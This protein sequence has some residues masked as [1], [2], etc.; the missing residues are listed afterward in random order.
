MKTLGAI[1]ANDVGAAKEIL[2]RTYEILDGIDMASLN[3]PKTKTPDVIGVSGVCVET[4]DAVT[5]AAHDL[6]IMASREAH[7]GHFITSFG[8]LDQLPSEDDPILCMTWGQFDSDSFIRASFNEFFGRRRSLIPYLGSS[9]NGSIHHYDEGYSA[10]SVIYRSSTH[11]PPE[12]PASPHLWLATTPEDIASGN[13][14]VGEV[15]RD[16]FPASSWH[17]R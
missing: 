4:S 6:G 17:H 10:N 2:D 5:R 15:A 16:E 3:E 8:P 7:L 1:G 13:Y 14:P 11:T 12:S 9:L